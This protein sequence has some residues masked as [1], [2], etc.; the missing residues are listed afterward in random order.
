MSRLHGC[1]FTVLSYHHYMHSLI[2]SKGGQYHN[3][4][5]IKDAPDIQGNFFSMSIDKY[6][7]Y[8]RSRQLTEAGLNVLYL[9]CIVTGSGDDLASIC[10]FWSHISRS[11]PA[12]RPN[13]T[14]TPFRACPEPSLSDGKD[15]RINVTL[16]NPLNAQP[17][18]TRPALAARPL[19]RLV[20]SSQLH[21][22]ANKNTVSCLPSPLGIIVGIPA[23]YIPLPPR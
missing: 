11:A 7:P 3:L 19:C 4:I 10:T 17:C 14:R 8:I 6:M 9:T 13:K 5:I 15:T 12:L 18:N 1:T 16:P 22:S 2:I 21:F 20:C 23:H